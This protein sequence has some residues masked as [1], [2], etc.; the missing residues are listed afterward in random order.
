MREILTRKKKEKKKKENGNKEA[1]NSLASQISNTAKFG[2]PCLEPLWTLWWG[3][4]FLSL[5]A[6]AFFLCAPQGKLVGI[7]IKKRPRPLR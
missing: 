5:L 4:L 1:L 6:F 3:L 2:I 7:K